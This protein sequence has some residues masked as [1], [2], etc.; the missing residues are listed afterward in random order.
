MCFANFRGRFFSRVG[1]TEFVVQISISAVGW[2]NRS[3]IQAVLVPRTS[4]ALVPC[5]NRH[6]LGSTKC[7]SA[8]RWLGGRCSQYTRFATVFH[9]PSA[10]ASPN[11]SLKAPNF[12]LEQYLNSSCPPGEIVPRAILPC[13]S[14][15][16]PRQI[17]YTTYS[18]TPWKE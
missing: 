8:Q 3:S 16:W 17:R 7:P 12:C 14:C 11:P 10:D 9:G 4:P 15:S 5:V 2:H 1:R 13:S 18:I 6:W